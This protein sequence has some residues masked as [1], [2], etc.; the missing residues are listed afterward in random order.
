[1]WR[2]IVFMSCMLLI[3]GQA[4]G[5]VS[6]TV[7][8]S[9]TEL[10]FADPKLYQ[11]V[12]AALAQQGFEPSQDALSEVR[13]LSLANCGITSLVGLEQLTNLS[14]LDLSFN[15]IRDLAPLRSLTQLAS[16]N[17]RETLVTDL[18]PLAE[19]TN[20]EYLNIHSVPVESV[21]PI[22]N[23]RNLE[24]LIMRNVYIGTETEF[25]S[26][27]T[28]L[29]RLNLRNTGITDTQVLA[30]LMQQGA[31]QN[32]HHLGVRAELDLRDNLLRSTSYADDYA[33]IR[34]FWTNI[35]D[36]QPVILPDVAVQQVMINEFMAS[37]G[38]TLQDRS[39]EYPDWIELYNPQPY[40][41]DLSGYYLSDD[42]ADPFKWKFPDGIRI[43]ADG[44][45]LIFATGKDSV[46][47]GDVHTN[48][49]LASSGEPIL[50]TDPNG[51]L[52]DYVPPQEQRRDVSYGRTSDGS[53]AFA[54][55][56]LPSP[57]SPN[58]SDRV[59]TDK[60]NPPDFSHIRGFYRE[61]FDL[62]LSSRDPDVAIYY[63]L[64][65][66]IPDQSSLVYQEPIRIGPENYKTTL[67]SHIK[68][69]GPFNLN[70]IE[71]DYTGRKQ[72][73][74]FLPWTPQNV[75]QGIVVRAVAYKEGALASDVETHTFFVDPNMFERYT[76]P[77]ISIVTDPKGFFDPAN[78]IYVAGVHYWDWR[79]GRPWHN[80]GNYTQRGMAWERPVHVEFFEPGG[81]FGFKLNMGARIH[82][83][84]TRSWPQKTLRLHARSSYEPPGLI[85]YPVF[86]NLTANGTGEPLTVF[87]RILLRNGGNHWSIDLF[88]DALMHELISHTKVDVMAYRPAIV[89]INGEYWGFTTSASVW[90]SITW[91]QTI[92]LIRTMW[93]LQPITMN[94]ITVIQVMNGTFIT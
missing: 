29:K 10:G 33:P 93:L 15:P 87:K 69:F 54:F 20:L 30:D 1:M 77:I 78:G 37:N 70:R 32:Q 49:S 79:P 80:P 46:I 4:V 16:L 58:L 28:R 72:S 17:L 47:L 44:Y 3:V 24:T 22:A 60:L 91:L 59:Y 84:I 21:E 25:L 2:T 45:R 11:Q 51:V 71:M 50:L 48:F 64:D 81:V 38:S 66:S 67:L 26:G 7:S 82:G 85:E 8:A 61:P 88:A 34:R 55:F 63:T 42:P 9:P 18:T 31:L 19:L 52:Q 75:F 27:L 41:V 12:T 43:P 53:G 36:R 94:W 89:F 74:A 6:T 14:T 92:I 56:S 57:G 40:S 65:G 39:R 23:L 73:Q 35:F 13:E 62:V 68:T 83:G 76:L 5:A 90:T 86:P